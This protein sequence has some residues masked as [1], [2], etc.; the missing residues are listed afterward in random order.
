MSGAELLAARARLLAQVEQAARV[1]APLW[2]LS[3]FIAVNPLWDLRQMP[4]DAA[5][6]HAARVLG[7]YGYPPV[8]LFAEA[9]AS[10]RVT[11]AD[12]RTALD[13]HGAVV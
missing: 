3:T 8:A 9:Y 6:A 12:L 1:I 11:A 10:R 13:D 5:I 2:P 7:I 4:F